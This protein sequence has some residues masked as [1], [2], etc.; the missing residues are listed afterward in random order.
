[1]M[2]KKS[3]IV[4]LVSGYVISSVLVLTLIAYAA[5][6]E[7]KNENS[8]RS[9]ITAMDRLNAG[10]YAKYIEL[11]KFDARIGSYGTFKGEAI[12]EGVI[13][14]TGNRGIVDMLAKVKFLDTDGAIIYEVVFRP[15][16]PSLG[17]VSLT[18][19]AIPYASG[20]NHR[21]IIKP[22]ESL[23]FKKILTSCP[24]EILSELKTGGAFTK[25]SGRWQGKVDF[26]P[27][28]VQF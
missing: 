16:E 17:T 12:V 26:E 7:L 14:N 20:S 15:Q 18:Q 2:K 1:M 5:Y 9:Y 10:Y 28:L 19:I 24:K 23:P 11:S 22:G 27:M 13:K 21:A 3:M 6:L 25:T 8:N 4:A